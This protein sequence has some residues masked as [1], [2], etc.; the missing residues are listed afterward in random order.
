MFGFFGKWRGGGAVRA[1]LMCAY[2]SCCAIKPWPCVP[3]RRRPPPYL[4]KEASTILP[5][6]PNIWVVPQGAFT[7]RSNSF[8]RRIQFLF[9][10]FSCLLF[11]ASWQVSSRRRCSDKF[12]P[13]TLMTGAR[14]CTGSRASPPGTLIS[15]A[16]NHEK[17]ERWHTKRK[18]V[19]GAKVGMERW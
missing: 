5:P 18:W 1:A 17:T 2:L 19:M 7:L 6:A 4:L 14:R 15:A 11:P 12:S 10:S 3:M 13:P 9:F 8:E 16:E